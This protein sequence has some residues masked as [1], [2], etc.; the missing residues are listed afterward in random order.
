MLPVPSTRGTLEASQASQSGPI[1]ALFPKENAL[2]NS[3]FAV[4]KNAVHN[5]ES[6]E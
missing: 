1:S 2:K 3:L 5:V 4:F 6:Y